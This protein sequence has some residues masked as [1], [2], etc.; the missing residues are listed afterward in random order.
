MPDSDAGWVYEDDGIDEVGATDDDDGVERAKKIREQSLDTDWGLAWY[1]Q[2]KQRMWS[3][4][5]AGLSNIAGSA[6][7]YIASLEKVPL[8]AK[9]IDTLIVYKAPSSYYAWAYPGPCDPPDMN[10]L[11]EKYVV[12]EDQLMKAK[13][14]ATLRLCV[15]PY[16]ITGKV[17]RRVDGE[18]IECKRSWPDREDPR[19]A[20]AI[21]WFTRM[22]RVIAVTHSKLVV[23]ANDNVAWGTLKGVGHAVKLLDTGMPKRT[24]HTRKDGVE[25]MLDP[26]LSDSQFN[27]C[28]R[29]VS[30]QL[31]QTKTWPNITEVVDAIN[32]MFGE[33][34][35]FLL[36]LERI[37]TL[38]VVVHIDHPMV[39][40]SAYQVT[41]G[42]GDTVPDRILR[43]WKQVW[44][45]VES[46]LHHGHKSDNALSLMIHDSHT[47]QILRQRK[48][49]KKPAAA[50]KKKSA[51]VKRTGPALEQ[52]IER[53][54]GMERKPEQKVQL[55]F[56]SEWSK[57]KKAKQAKQAKQAKKR[58]GQRRIDTMFTTK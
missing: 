35:S 5:T 40:H 48:L 13:S 16:P 24:K 39:Y 27:E 25:V 10:A 23:I 1:S 28:L 37:E 55:S 46:F 15:L 14:L 45:Y 38:L 7:D 36:Q 33:V 54:K 20:R 29:L 11:S 17:K 42:L 32:E 43:R 58:N 30:S 19:Y 57:K 8:A 6:D 18:L 9:S 21:E 2:D 49:A 53:M 12:I 47:V 44:R 31:D 50:K 3:A 34:E 51:Q 52:Y 22:I 56:E 4:V 41:N 26:K